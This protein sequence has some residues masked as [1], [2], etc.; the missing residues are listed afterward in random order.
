MNTLCGRCGEHRPLYARGLCGRCYKRCQTDGTLTDH[1]RRTRP[2]TEVVAE[3]ELL[4]AAGHTTAQ[5]AQRLGMKTDTFT[6][7]LRRG[8]TQ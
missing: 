7:A 3:W 5:A 4:R 2:Y 6:A 8:A 1:E